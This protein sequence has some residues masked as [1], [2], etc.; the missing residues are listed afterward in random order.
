MIDGEK[1]PLTLNGAGLR[2]RYTARVYVAGLYLTQPATT[3]EAVLESAATRAVALHLRRDS[4]SEQIASALIGSVSK[5]HSP[6]EMKSLRDRLNQFKIMMPDIK[7]NEIVYLEFP[8]NGETRVRLNTDL[9]GTLQGADF[10][11]AL[12]R[13]WLGAKPVDTGLKR[14]LLGA[15]S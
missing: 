5:N 4:D 13:I 8:A 1:A 10:Q 11:R 15:R 6:G 2:T 12:L 9:R 3:P 7:R 14:L